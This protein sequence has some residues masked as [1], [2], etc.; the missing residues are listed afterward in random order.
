VYSDKQPYTPLYA[1]Q[2]AQVVSNFRRRH[3]FYPDCNATNDRIADLPVRRQLDELT[4]GELAA[5]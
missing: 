1:L 2:T 3:G 5:V 4:T